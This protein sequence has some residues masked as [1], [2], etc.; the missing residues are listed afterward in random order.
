MNRRGFLR[1]ALASTATIVVAPA[2]VLDELNEPH[3]RR[4]YIDM[5]KNMPQC[6]GGPPNWLGHLRQYQLD[7]MDEYLRIASK[8]VS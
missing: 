1:A 5:G 6:A 2:C 3:I 7:A 8:Y 4:T